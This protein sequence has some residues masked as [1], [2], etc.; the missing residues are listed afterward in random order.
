MSTDPSASGG[1][2]DCESPVSPQVRAQFNKVAWTVPFLISILLITVP[3]LG[4]G[5]TAATALVTLLL[6]GGGLALV[7]R[8]RAR[9]YRE[10]TFENSL[11]IPTSLR[12]S[13]LK[14]ESFAHMRKDPTVIGGWADLTPD[15]SVWYPGPLHKSIS[16]VEIPWHRVAKAILVSQRS[17]VTAMTL[18]LGGA[19][20][21]LFLNGPKPDVLARFLRSVRP[22]VS[23]EVLSPRVESGPAM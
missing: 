18:C 11:H 14:G 12:P 1:H 6:V 5:P 23:V 2:S 8:H 17:V 22:P 4:W 9:K 10:L 13:E 20:A 16:Q 15:V 7:F 19:Q 3:H 21:T